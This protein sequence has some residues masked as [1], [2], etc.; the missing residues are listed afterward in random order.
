[1][2]EDDLPEGG[3]ADHHQHLGLARRPQGLNYKAIIAADED[4]E[5]FPT[6]PYLTPAALFEPLVRILYDNVFVNKMPVQ[7][8]LAQIEKETLALLEKGKRETE[9]RK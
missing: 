4:T 7:E 8:G 5:P 1:V 9:A 6:T 3:P 2:A